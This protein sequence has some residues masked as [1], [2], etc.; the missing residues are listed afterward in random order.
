MSVFDRGFK[1]EIPD[2]VGHRCF[3]GIGEMMAFMLENGAYEWNYDDN[4]GVWRVPQWRKGIEKMS[5]IVQEY[6][7]RY[8]CE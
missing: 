4:F 2:N 7:D 8:G 5:G 6:C 1:C 3:A